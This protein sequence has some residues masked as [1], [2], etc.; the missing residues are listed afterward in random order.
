MSEMNHDDHERMKKLIMLTKNTEEVKA[1]LN[2]ID[3]Q[4]QPPHK[5]NEERKED[6]GENNRKE[7]HQDTVK[8]VN[9][10]K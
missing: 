3:A 7:G 8:E 2:E 9:T 6:V 1:I 5:E 10:V 4:K